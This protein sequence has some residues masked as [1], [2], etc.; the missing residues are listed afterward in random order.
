MDSTA[1]LLALGP[2]MMR[3]GSPGMAWEMMNVRMLTPMSTGMAART[4]LMM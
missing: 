3:A 1:S 2:T 4:R